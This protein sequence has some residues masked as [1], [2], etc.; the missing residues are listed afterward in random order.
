MQA[1]ILYIEQVTFAIGVEETIEFH[2]CQV[3]LLLILIFLQ[4]SMTLFLAL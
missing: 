2:F 3:L 4:V 1:T